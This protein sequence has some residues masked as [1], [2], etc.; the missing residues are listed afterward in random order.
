MI[1]SIEWAEQQQTF[2]GKQIERTEK[3]WGEEGE[4][5]RERDKKKPNKIMR[6]R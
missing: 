4:G 2:I 6:E 3:K 1:L 5:Q